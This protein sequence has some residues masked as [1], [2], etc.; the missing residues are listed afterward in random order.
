MIL[1]FKKKSLSKAKHYFIY[2][3]EKFWKKPEEDNGEYPC[4]V[5]A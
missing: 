2:Y 5:V 4:H 1:F 3:S